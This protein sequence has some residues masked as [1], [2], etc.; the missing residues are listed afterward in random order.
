ME[1]AR[2]SEGAAGQLWARVLPWQGLANPGKGKQEEVPAFLEGWL[3]SQ[4]GA[5][6][7]TLRVAG[8]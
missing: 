3:A 2:T 8:S 5:Q 4:R 1:A 6:S 7:H